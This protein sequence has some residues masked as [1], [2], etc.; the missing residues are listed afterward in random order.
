MKLSGQTRMTKAA[1]AKMMMVVDLAGASKRE[2]Q[3]VS[4]VPDLIDARA[5]QTHA[6]L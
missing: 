2:P 6:N 5:S 4:G 3:C 1:A